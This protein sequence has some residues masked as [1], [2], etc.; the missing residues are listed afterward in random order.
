MS[1]F[2]IVLNNFE[3]IFQMRFGSNTWIP[4]STIYI[5]RQYVFD[6][7]NSEHRLTKTS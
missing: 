7:S 6:S 4:S 5:E 2:Y 1:K 3:Q